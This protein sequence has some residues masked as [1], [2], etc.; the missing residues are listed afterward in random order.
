MLHKVREISEEFKLPIMTYGH[1]GDGNLHT[2]MCID[3]LSDEE[4]EKLNKAADKIHRTAIGIGGTVTAEHGVGSARADYLELE[5]GKALDVMILI[6]NA[7]DPKGIM[8][9]GKMGV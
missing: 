4:W 9:P 1:I 2:G 8:N 5:L 3:V 6:K 7:L